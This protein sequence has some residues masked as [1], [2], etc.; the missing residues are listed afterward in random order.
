MHVV[1]NPLNE[2]GNLRRRKKKKSNYRFL[3]II[4]GDLKLSIKILPNDIAS[5][6]SF[7]IP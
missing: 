4:Y 2:R 7:S 3:T 5:K 1:I 6:L